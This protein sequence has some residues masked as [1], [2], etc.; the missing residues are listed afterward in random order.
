MSSKVE[1]RD[2]KV[3]TELMNSVLK[4]NDSYTIIN[5]LIYVQIDSCKFDFRRANL[6]TLF[7]TN[8]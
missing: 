4:A 3:L 6:Y 5:G 8:L 1:L 7:N 2:R